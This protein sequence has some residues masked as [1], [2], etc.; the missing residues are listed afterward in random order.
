MKN[1][2][3]LSLPFIKIFPFTR[4]IFFLFRKESIKHRKSI[5][6]DSSFNFFRNCESFSILMIEK[7]QLKLPRS[8]NIIGI[9]SPAIFCNTQSPF[10]DFNET[11]KQR[12]DFQEPPDDD[13]VKKGEFALYRQPGSILVPARQSVLKV[14]TLY[15]DT[16]DGN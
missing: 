10:G 14:R 5:K 12:A 16:A 8:E 4:G 13:L 11:R 2:I 6:I 1:Y 3:T 9:T 7:E 15:S